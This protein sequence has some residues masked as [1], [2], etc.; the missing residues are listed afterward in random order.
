LNTDEWLMTN[1]LIAVGTRP[2]I[3]KM[4]PIVNALTNRNEPFKLVYSGQH[5]DYNLS[6]QFI[7]ELN[8]PLPEYNLKVREVSPGRQ[9][10]R[11]IIGFE[12]IIKKEKPLITLVEGDTNSVLAAAIA[13]NK[14]NI[15]LGHVEAGLRSFD[16]RMPEEHNRRLVDH[17]SNYLFAPTENARRNLEREAVWGK[18]YVTGN[19]VI[20]A[21]QKHLPLAEKK[22]RI[23]EKINLDEYLL[24][25]IH[26][27]ENV[28]N[29][30][31]LRNLI[32]AFTSA[33]LPV[34]FPVHP[35]T[36]KRLRQTKLWRKALSSNN[37]LILPPV[38]YF[39]FLL[40]MKNCK[41][42]LTDSGGIQEEATVP[43]VRKRV[44]VLRL[45]TERL[46]AIE[47][48]FAK[49][50]GVRKENIL[51]AIDE[52]LNGEPL[53]DKSP[54]GDGHAGEKIVDIILREIYS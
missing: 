25:T 37:L 45:S 32:E 8:L 41:M 31:V 21:C 47:A 53:P 7:K 11:I 29:P 23:M 14:Q 38:G 43:S 6:L 1:I 10:G 9:T 16:L 19:T 50:V 51:K 5:H 4:A 54:Y 20:D 22:S 39:D 33:P 28:D 26:R 35:R 12:R 36:A 42:I 44:L 49:V 15:T 27:A 48:G 34:V 3:I 40:L 2:E 13:S 52:A 18:I 46:E 30:E 17:I 24:A